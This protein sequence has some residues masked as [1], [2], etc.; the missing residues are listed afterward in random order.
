MWLVCIAVI[1]YASTSLSI[2]MALD[3]LP[4]K[5]LLISPSKPPLPPGA[6]APND[7]LKNLASAMPP[8]APLGW[9]PWAPRPLPSMP[10]TRN[11][12]LGSPPTIPNQD[13]ERQ[14]GGLVM[15]GLVA[16]NK[17]INKEPAVSDEDK[18]ALIQ[19]QIN[20]LPDPEKISD[21]PLTRAMMIGSLIAGMGGVR[22]LRGKTLQ[23][24]YGCT[25]N[26]LFGVYG[27]SMNMMSGM[28]ASS[29]S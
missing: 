8:L 1:C 10:Q 9:S 21:D 11:A 14:L 26:P 22:G 3:P 7:G 23:R 4:A 5:R 15:P 2:E 12:G 6:M 25:Q 13:M 28:M 29:S 27:A 24:F 17:I 20:P 19:S 18:A 16:A